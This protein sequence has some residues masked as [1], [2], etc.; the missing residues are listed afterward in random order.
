MKKEE[1]E[2]VSLTPAELYR[3]LIC[4]LRYG[5]SRNNHLMP[6]SAYKEA[7]DYLSRM[8]EVDEDLAASTAIQLAEECIS[9]QI[10][11]NFY[12]GLDDDC[13][14]REE[15]VKFANSLIKFAKDHGNPNP[16]YNFD[17]L[18]RNVGKAD[19]LKY[20]VWELK[21]YDFESNLSPTWEFV[22]GLDRAEI[23]SGISK[24]TA[25]ESLFKKVI[26][27]DSAVFSGRLSVKNPPEQSNLVVGE[28]FR[29]AEPEALSGRVF[30]VILSEESGIAYA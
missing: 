26:K 12:D 10:C 15:S 21:D 2:K 7:L 29:I 24:A 18:L 6:S 16:P 20:D 13:Q 25:Y 30:C 3:L 17:S 11:M 23:E 8:A 28:I 14:N 5:Y 19:S 27:A 1:T 22:K 4:C 9:D